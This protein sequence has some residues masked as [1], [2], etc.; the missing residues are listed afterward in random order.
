MEGSRPVQRIVLGANQYGK[1]EVRVVRVR[2]DGPRHE[3]RDLN[4]SI[5]LAGDLA[6]VHRCGDN[7]TVLPTDSQ[8]NT[9]Y[10][11]ARQHGIDQVEDFGLLLARHFVD[12]QPAI[13][14]A[15][16]RL[17]EYGW[18]RLGP[19]SFARDG[20]ES[21]T[22]TVTVGPDRTTVESGLTGLVL[23]NSTGSEFN[24][25]VRDPYT[26]LAETDDR[27]LATAVEANWRHRDVDPADPIADRD[28]A[29]SY[30]AV[31]AALIAAFVETYS[32]SLQQTL[33]AMGHRVL[34]ERPEIA[35]LR[36]ALPNQHHLPVDLTPF[37]LTNPGE[38]FV[39]TDRPYGL[40]EG[41]VTRADS[42]D[43]IDAPPDGRS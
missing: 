19:H 12:S 22:A 5:A 43:S 40:I 15:T 32:R 42:A 35:E 14:R 37:G 11:F 6:E 8:K 24:G 29:G 4:V 18:R 17:T 38:V 16:V 3:L 2:R 10:A 25:F 21:R 27:I 9:V 1:A 13:T 33:Y 26:T 30:A 34:A 31:R 36:L 20:A 39:A 23:L 7:A 28:W 41:T